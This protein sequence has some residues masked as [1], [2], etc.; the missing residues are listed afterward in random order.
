[1]KVNVTIAQTDFSKLMM[2]ALTVNRAK[3]VRLI[4]QIGLV[5]SNGITKQELKLI[6]F[7]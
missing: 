4:L 5:A 7:K 3:V 2:E 6:I 1:M